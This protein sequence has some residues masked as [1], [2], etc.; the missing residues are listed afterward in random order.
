MIRLLIISPMPPAIGGVSVS[1]NRLLLNMRNDGNDVTAFNVRFKNSAYNTPLN[2]ALKYFII[3]FYIIFHK[4]YD[5]IHCHVPGILRKLYI[6]LFKPFYKGA[7]LLYTVHGDVFPFAQNKCAEFALK[8]ADKIICVKQ[9]DSSKLPIVLREKSVDIPAFILPRSEDT[10]F[11][12]DSIV[13]FCRRQND[14][15]LLIFN[16]AAIVDENWNDLYGFMDM[17][18]AYQK[19]KER[20]HYRLLMIL[21]G[22]PKGKAAKNLVLKVKQITVNDPDVRFVENENFEL[23]PLFKY[24]NLYVRPTKTDGDS[25]SIREAIAMG[26]KVVTTSIV[27]RPEGCFLY[28]YPAQLAST[29][30]EAINSEITTVNISKDYYQEIKNLYTELMEA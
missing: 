2:L 20:G 14:K 1:N 26:C 8:R 24:A 19:L 7:K 28:E 15:K 22:M 3:P 13:E 5:I 29:I 9:G 23:C 12:P 4:R 27:T 6:S 25:L 18:K 21:N 10:S 16:G 30:E 17:I 11:I